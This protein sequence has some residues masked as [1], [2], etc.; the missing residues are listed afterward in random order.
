MPLTSVD[1]Q[2]PPDEV[3]GDTVK[4]A[5]AAPAGLLTVNCCVAAAEPTWEEKLRLVGL[6]V[7]TTPPEPPTCSVIG[8]VWVTPVLNVIEPL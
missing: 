6:T 2:L 1:N 3:V 7:T 8:T 5:A 4:F